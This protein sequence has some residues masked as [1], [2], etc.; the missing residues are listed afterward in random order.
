MQGGTLNRAAWLHT[1]AQPGPKLG[2]H[3]SKEEALALCHIPLRSPHWLQ[4]VGFGVTFLKAIPNYQVF[5]GLRC[6]VIAPRRTEAN[7]WWA[8]GSVTA[9]TCSW[10]AMFEGS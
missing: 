10:A 1:P 9:Y 7:W 8:V 6:V 3:G 4:F 5:K 2:Q